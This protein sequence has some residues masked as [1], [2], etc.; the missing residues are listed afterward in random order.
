MSQVALQR[1]KMVVEE[2]ME[3]TKSK[4]K[5]VT[6]DAFFLAGTVLYASSWETSSRTGMATPSLTQ[7]ALPPNCSKTFLTEP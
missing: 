2:G 7:L 5:R 3:E 6:M 4:V 1:K